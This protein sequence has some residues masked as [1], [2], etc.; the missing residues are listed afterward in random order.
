MPRAVLPLSL[1]LLLLAAAPRAA[2]A[3]ARRE[4]QAH[5]ARA[6]ELHGAGAF[7]EALTELTIAYSLDPQPD[8][9]YAIAQTHVQLGNCP[10]AILFYRRFLSTRPERV[11]A[12]AALEA[13][14]V[15]ETA[16]PPPEPPPEPEPVVEPPPPPPE[17]VVEPPPPPPPPPPA[18]GA[19]P[20]HRDPLGL[21][22]VGGGVVLGAAAG[23]TYALARG[24]LDRAEDAPTYAEYVD[25]VDRGRTRRLVAGVLGGAGVTV[26][27][28]GVVRLARRGARSPDVAVVP[29]AG[30]GLVSWAG[31]F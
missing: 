9:L 24:D 14:E 3:D 25:L 4:A 12:S 28:I 18:P 13:I 23:V 26:A 1:L 17:P 19:R 22:L 5:L 31:R 15:C 11:A 10:Q 20:W 2:Q 6:T 8:L 30:G 7:A 29:T 27:V 16:P 21:A